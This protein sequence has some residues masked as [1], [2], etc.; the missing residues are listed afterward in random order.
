MLAHFDLDEL[1]ELKISFRFNDAIIRN[2]ITSCKYPITKKSVMMS[3]K[4]D[5]K[6]L[7]NKIKK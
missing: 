4:D 6:D 3:K 2:L 1:K 7:K 5:K